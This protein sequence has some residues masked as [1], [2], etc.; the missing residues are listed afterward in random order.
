MYS[1]NGDGQLQSLSG[2]V[3][4][5]LEYDVFDNISRRN[6]LRYIYDSEYRLVGVRDAANNLVVSYSYDGKE[7]RV[8]TTRP[9][10]PSDVV[11]HYDHVGNRIAETTG[12]GLL[13]KEYIV[14]ESRT[15]AEVDFR[16]LLVDTGELDFGA[17]GKGLSPVT[18]TAPITITNRSSDPISINNV[19]IAGTVF[20]LGEATP[21]VIPANGFKVVLVE[22]SPPRLGTYEG[23]LSICAEGGLQLD[24]GLRGSAVQTPTGPNS[25]AF[26]L[27]GSICIE[28]A[29]V[30]NP[31]TVDPFN[32]A[33]FGLQ[34]GLLDGVLEVN[35]GQICM[36][37]G[38]SRSQGGGLRGGEVIYTS[39]TTRTL[40]MSGGGP[41]Q[42]TVWQ[43][44][45]ETSGDDG[46][47][48]NSGQTPGDAAG[49]RVALGDLDGDGDLDAFLS[50]EASPNEV[51]M[52]DG[53][54]NFSDSGQRLRAHPSLHS[55]DAALADLDADGDLDAFVAN[56]GFSGEPRYNTVW[57]NDGDGQFTN[58]GQTLG[59]SESR[60]VSVGDLDGDGDLDAFVVNSDVIFVPGYQP[61]NRVW[62]NDGGGTFTG[63]QSLGRERSMGVRLGDVDRDGDLDIL[64]ANNGGDEEDKIWLNR[65]NATFQ[66]GQSLGRRD[67]YVE[68]GDIN[69]DGHLDAF[70]GRTAWLNNGLGEFTQFWDPGVLTVWHAAL[71]DLNG[72]G[73]LDLYV[74]DAS[75]N[76][77]VWLNDGAGVFSDSGQRLATGS[78]EDIA[79]GD[80]DGDGDLD[81]FVSQE[82]LSGPLNNQIW[83]N[84]EMTPVGDFQVF[85]PVA[86]KRP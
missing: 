78:T 33:V 50:S 69:G 25:H 18:V 48:Q 31:S 16:P 64:V 7:R 29:Q 43:V 84:G 28:Y 70:L 42:P 71:G 60:A 59:S 26:P 3:N 52:N 23:K 6:D 5:T 77:Q 74:L 54:G 80:L 53:A 73:A 46:F 8:L 56:Y 22:F 67:Q 13:L 79:L 30:V 66:G 65:G 63:G 2:R 17:V 62:L 41:D 55:S 82:P 72:D 1:Y 20:A 11:Y 75:G 35:G 44:Q 34:T 24:V 57:T 85:V 49:D 9:E 47:Y 36:T 40:F 39:A 86:L 4:M 19:V 61:R 12:T 45:V 81:T 83:I 10:C 21:I 51:W 32:F 15:I 68:L 27:D 37:P 76:D 38:G 58:T 14:A